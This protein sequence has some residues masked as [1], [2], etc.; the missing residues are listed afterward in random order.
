MKTCGM[1]GEIVGKAASICIKNSTN[2]RGV[3]TNHLTQLHE[4]MKQSG[5]KRV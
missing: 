5:S 1:M 4:L 3:Y 2:P